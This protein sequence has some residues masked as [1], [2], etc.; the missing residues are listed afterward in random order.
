VELLRFFEHAV[1][2]R[3]AD[4][5]P[6]TNLPTDEELAALDGAAMPALD[7]P[8]AHVPPVDLPELDGSVPPPP[9][10]PPGTAFVES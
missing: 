3:A 9:A 5:V 7:I 10:A 4:P 6:S 8:P 1:G 2:G